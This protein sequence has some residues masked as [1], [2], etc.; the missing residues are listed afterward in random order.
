MDLALATAGTSVRI[1]AAVSPGWGAAVAMPLF[2]YVARPRPVHR[3]DEPTMSRARR[4]T[5]RIPGVDRRGVDVETYEWGAGSRT[6]VLAHGWSGRASQFAVLVRELVASGLRVVAFDAPAHGSSAGRRTY[7]VDWLDVFAAL[8]ERHGAFDGMVGH[9]FGGLATLVGVA[10]GTASERVVTIAAP[11][12]ADMLLSQFQA[13]L[14]YSDGV[15]ARMRERFVERYFPGEPDPFAWLSSVRRPLA[16]GVP[17]LVAHDDG[18]RVV[19][20]AEAGR[21]V[22]ANPGARMLP[23]TGLGHN[24]ILASDVVLDA[25]LAH[26][27]T[28]VCTPAPVVRLDGP[29]VVTSAA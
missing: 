11:A 25:V 22:A 19:P 14:R 21:I 12:D 20:F 3:D 26:L 5:V 27:E 15:S 1:A 4:R 9:S 13:M 29:E 6:V 23:T 28:P 10:G 16:A 2:A 17:L 24:R 18:D 8:Q 7:L